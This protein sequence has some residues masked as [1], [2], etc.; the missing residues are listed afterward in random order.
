MNAIDVQA[1]LLYPDGREES[2]GPM[3]K[4][5]FAKLLLARSISLF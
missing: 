2:P 4:S 1:V 5:D 3:P